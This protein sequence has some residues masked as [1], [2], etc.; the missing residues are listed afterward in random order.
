[1]TDSEAM[2]SV[3]EIL[4]PD[5][6]SKKNI[7]EFL[8]LAVYVCNKNGHV[9]Y[10]NENAVRL[11]ACKPPTDEQEKFYTFYKIWTLEGTLIPP[12][13]TPMAI[14]LQTGRSFRNMEAIME[15]SDSSKFY[16]L[17]NIDP[18]FNDANDLI[19]AITTIQDI[20]DL[21]KAEQA[22]EKTIS[23][24]TLDLEKKNEELKRSEDRYHKMIEE[25]EDYA[26]ILLDKNGI[27][28][29]WNKG[30]QKI[31]GY[32]DKEIIGKSFKTFYS[33]EDRDAEL[34]DQLLNKARL[35]GKVVHEGW[36][37]RKNGTKFWGSVVITALHDEKNDVIGFSKVT[38]DLTERKAAEDKLR[39]YASELEYQNQELEQFTHITSHD[40]QE[41]L[42]KINM[43]S[44]MIRETDYDKLSESSK[45]KFDKIIDAAQ[46]LSNALK[47]LLSFA[48]LT[49]EEQFKEVNLSEIVHNVMNDL[50]LLISQ[51]G[52]HIHVDRLPV[53]NAMPLQMHQLFYNILN[54][55]LK[56]TREAIIPEI[57]ISAHEFKPVLGQLNPHLDTSKTYYEIIVK[58]NGIGFE[59]KD[60]EKIFGMF[61]RLRTQEEYKGSGIGLALC[62][63]V[64]L[65]H[66]GDI[67][68][69]SE[70]G[71]GTEFHLILP[72]DQ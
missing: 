31:K 18:L 33:K 46:R 15:K 16:G 43:F 53:V 40:L 10:C 29:N 41:P 70:P 2:S 50:E 26:I 14:T 36:R 64:A 45:T 65:N 4:Y 28:Q 42:R 38:R 32:T 67:F 61:Q 54:N 47:D 55:A 57:E 44:Q 52:A 12:D 56:F 11:W 58:D 21:K 69:R 49:K 51:K 25:V 3:K 8:P 48:R 72:K 9:T 17:I 19:G 68:A 34:P 22:L 71:K 63:R 35:E 5:Q 37:V 59:Q 20:S 60:A 66:H 1:M 39:Q 13:Q 27:I 7:L 24:R 6:F 23:D 30:A 62:K